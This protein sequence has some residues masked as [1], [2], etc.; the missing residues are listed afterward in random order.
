MNSGTKLDPGTMDTIV[1]RV[2]RRLRE[3][4]EPEGVMLTVDRGETKYDDEWLYVSINPP[5]GGG[6]RASEYAEWFT[7]IERELRDDREVEVNVLLVPTY[8][9][10]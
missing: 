2:E 9:G 4:G 10:S 6:H 3:L 7:L 1:S 5:T 8:P